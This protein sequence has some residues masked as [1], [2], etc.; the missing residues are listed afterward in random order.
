VFYG[1]QV[2]LIVGLTHRYLIN[3]FDSTTQLLCSHYH[4]DIHLTPT[5]SC[6]E[7]IR[8]YRNCRP[9]IEDYPHEPLVYIMISTS[10]PLLAVMNIFEPIV[11]V[12]LQLKITHMS[13]SC[14]SRWI[15]APIGLY[16]IITLSIY[17]TKEYTNIIVVLWRPH[18]QPLHLRY[19]Q[20]Q[21]L[22]R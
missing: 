11:T 17:T 15:I 13:H 19:T 21:T 6:Y 7:Y 4:H 10:L 12:G 14:T 2:D 16:N 3:P 18:L 20:S 22:C 9:T 8:T 5:S 1:H